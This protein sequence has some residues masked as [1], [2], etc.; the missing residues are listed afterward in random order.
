VTASGYKTRTDPN[1]P[2]VRLWDARTGKELRAF[3]GHPNGAS[4]ASF[5]ADGRRIVTASQ[6]NTAQ[7][8][9]VD[10]GKEVAVLKGHTGAVLRAAFSPDGKR[11][12]TASQDNTARLWDAQSGK[13][14][15]VLK[16]HMRAVLSAAFSPDGKR[17]VTASDDNTVRL[18]DADSGRVVSVLIGAPGA[19]LSAAFSPDGKRL[20]MA[21][22]DTTARLWDVESGKEVAVLKGHEGPVLSAAFSP[23]GKRLVTAS[24]DNTAR[25]WD[26]QSGTLLQT[27]TGHKDAVAFA[28]FSPDGSR[29]ATAS[30]D[31]SV[32]FWSLTRTLGIP[33]VHG[34]ASSSAGAVWIVGAGGYA[35]YSR[36]GR[37]WTRVSLADETDLIAVTAI[38]AETGIALTAN[39]KLVFLNSRASGGAQNAG[40]TQLTAQQQQSE[41]VGQARTVEDPPAGERQ[42]RTLAFLTANDGWVAGDGGLILHTVDG[43]GTWSPPLHTKDGLT[44]ADLHIESSQVGWAVGKYADGR[45]TVVAANRPE[46]AEGPDAWHELP[47]H[48]GPWYFLLGIPALL[49]CGFLTLRAWRADP[50]PPQDSIEEVATSDVP[51]RWNEPDAR[52]L[53]PLARGLSRFLRNVNTQPPLTL[54]ITGRWGSGKSSLMSLLMSDLQRYG[55]RAVWFN[56]WHHR[57]EEHLLAALFEAIRHNAPPGWWSWP[58]LAFRA[59]LLWSRS[60]RSLLNLVYI[61]LFA[62]I[63]LITMRAA[64]PVFPVEELDQMLHRAV[65]FV[66]HDVA[67]TWRAALGLALAGSGGVALL[68]LWLRGKLVALPA[69]PAKLALAL[70]RRASLGD[71][72]DKLAFRHRFG[73]QFEDVCNAL[74]TRTSPGLVILIDDLDRCQ[75]E[76]VLKILEAINYLVSAGPCI[77]VLG[78]DRRQ[79]EYCVGLGFEKLVEGLPEEE[80]I[81]AADETPDKAGKQR[82]FARHYLEKLINIEVSVP[83]LDEAATDALL[84]RGTNAARP[85]DGDAPGW[86]QRTKRVGNAAFQIARVGLL[87]VV[88]GFL[89]T[90]GVERLREPGIAAAPTS[91][92]AVP[93]T[94]PLSGAA[95]TPV[96]SSPAQPQGQQGANFE[97]ARIELKIPPST[98]EVP[99]SRRWLWWAPTLLM[100]GV[101]LLFGVA[102]AAHRQRQVVQDSPRFAKALQSVKP[103]LAT[104]NATPRAI[105]RYQN[106]MRYLAAR[107]RPAVYEP[108]RIDSL[109]HWV[110]GRLGRPLVPAAWFEEQPRQAI[111]EPALIL[112][113]ALEL[114]APKAFANPAELFTKLEHGTPADQPS[115]EQIEAWSKVRDAFAT[116]GL[117]MPTAPE[118]ARYATFVLNKGRKG[119]SHSAD[120]VPFPRDA[121]EPRSL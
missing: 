63:A 39:N 101:S 98:L 87:A 25:L 94:V 107:L 34:I 60:R 55:G 46:A 32:R 108:D 45:Q 91:S 22:Q 111:D 15:A 21:C 72:S 5:S 1:N 53:K 88:A 28:A 52:V 106:R 4:S 38:G 57:E 109:L 36:D 62:G 74:L 9:E 105:K 23:D 69:N 30:V 79:I 104:I 112:L 120:V 71:F 68:A 50:A 85:D 78:M 51:L 27:M 41:V 37:S 19:V 103:L 81:Y 47:H 67:E 20:V 115:D 3:T 95:S 96:S 83:A 82:A 99:A 76:D 80:L 73:E 77:V 70:A 121:T 61:T 40:Q 89:L 44:L 86:L 110:G 24:D 48:V 118:I 54:A 42:L 113:G 17:V 29:I 66:G 49:L 56:A 90:W 43:G 117:A 65:G 58:G 13:E 93:A 84:L 31:G 97:P 100:I 116:Q 8:W 35:T 12:V 59:R 16:G 11:V 10:S 102:A 18:W 7:L 33:W 92:A 119:P 75:P 114:F 14:V 6:D 64:L 26:A 2:P